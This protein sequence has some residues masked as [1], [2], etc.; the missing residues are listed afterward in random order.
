MKTTMKA[1]RRV[2]RAFLLAVTLAAA[3][4]AQGERD[5]PNSVQS[6]DYAFLGGGRIAIKIAFKSDLKEPP[7]VFA[8]FHP[9]TRIVLEFDDMRSALGREPI[10]VRQRELVSLQVVRSGR[11]A[12]VIIGLLGPMIRETDVAGKELIVMLR[13]PDLQ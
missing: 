3:P 5:A 12:R 7:G 6:I 2:C 11:R 9:A 13:R 4:S 10:E 8:T 1:V